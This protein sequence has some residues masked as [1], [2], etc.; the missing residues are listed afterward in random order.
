M[1]IFLERQWK[2]CR[3]EDGTVY[4]IGKLYINGEF[5]C[6]TIEDE[7]RGL[8]Q[9]MSLNEIRERKVYGLTA[10]PTGIYRVSISYSPRFKRSLPMIHDV[11]GY[12]GIRIHSGNT[13]RD[14]LGC[15]IVGE[16]KEKGKVLNSKVTMNNL[17][18]KLGQAKGEITIEI[19]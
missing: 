12:V 8:M 5:F 4:C 15:V 7:D 3:R 1:K 6:N 9:D 10:I 14:S 18:E 16:N 2:N 11:P 19:V 13:E 17:M